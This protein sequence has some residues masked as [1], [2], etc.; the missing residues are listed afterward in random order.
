MDTENKETQQFE[1]PT[2]SKIDEVLDTLDPEQKEV[3][4]QAFAYIKQET[5]SGPL[6]PP[7]MLKAY[8]DIIPD[9]PQRILAM[10]EKQSDHRMK[11]EKNII[12]TSKTESLCG[13]ILG[14]TIAVL[15]IV[16]ASYL[17]MNGHDN[18]AI[19]IPVSVASL[20]AV[21]VVSKKK[22]KSKEDDE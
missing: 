2:R 8:G 9:A 18:L 15:C 5:F 16:A 22:S 3:I 17:G 7:E 1:L 11:C 4:T 20:A 10:A 6:P 14:F 21:F 12:S 19:S 13:Q